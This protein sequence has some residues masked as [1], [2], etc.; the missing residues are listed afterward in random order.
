M[1]AQT[2]FQLDKKTWKLHQIG[3]FEWLDRDGAVLHRVTDKPVYEATLVKYGDLGC[4]VPAANTKLSGI[5]E[6]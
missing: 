5:T 4:K 1:P 6:H 2:L 3:E